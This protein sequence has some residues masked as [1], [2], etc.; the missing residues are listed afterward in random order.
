[1]TN[2]WRTL[3]NPPPESLE[4]ARLQL[5]H[6]AQI[7]AAVGIY[8]LEPESD[9]GH[10]NLGWSD[11]LGALVS[12]ATADERPFQAA[13]RVAGLTL[14]LLD[15]DGRAANRFPLSG[16]KLHQGYEWLTSAIDTFTGKPPRNAIA[17]PPFELPFHPVAVD[18]TISGEPKEAFEELARWFSNAGHILRRVS[19]EREN[20]SDVRCWP[21]HFDIAALIQI[22]PHESP[23][24]ARSIGIG[25]APGDSSYP[26]PYYYVSPYPA[27]KHAELPRLSGG[28]EWHT[29]GWFGAALPATKLLEG[30]SGSEQG[31]R[32]QRFL[33]S[34]IEASYKWLGD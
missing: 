28:G 27:P 1:M 13:I 4:D 33:E 25:M 3:G 2:A 30:G 14:L 26:E 23:E 24:Q 20:A 8:L 31:R 5:H 10:T 18:E 12:H 32:T 29:E 15:S 6:C 34:A 21:H 9:D 7:A 11:D 17:P 22:D 16:S 19:S